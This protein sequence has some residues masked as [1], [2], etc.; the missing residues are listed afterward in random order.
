MNLDDCITALRSSDDIPKAAL[1]AG[2][3]HAD[4]LA[5]PLRLFP[6]RAA[7]C[8]TRLLLS[9]WDREPNEL[10]RLIELADMEAD[11]K[12]ARLRRA[13]TPHVRWAHRTVGDGKKFKECCGS[14]SGSTVH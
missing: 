8:L 10:F 14:D 9:A 5:P 1:T 3:V 7:Q 2:V 4:T 12:W 13:G 6:D 11:A